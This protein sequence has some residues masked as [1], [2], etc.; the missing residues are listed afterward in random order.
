MFSEKELLIWSLTRR[1]NRLKAF[2]YSNSL[3]ILGM[4]IKFIGN[5]MELRNLLLLS[6][7][8]NE[9]LR[10]EVLQQ[11]LLRSSQHNLARKRKTL[12]LKLLKIDAHYV[13]AEFESY[14]QQSLLEIPK[15]VSDAIDVDVNRSFNNLK[16]ISP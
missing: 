5:D 12:W 8:F 10:N 14:Y 7:D 13:K 2:G 9:I 15:Q 3:Q 11:A 16:Q 6:R 4:T 1:G